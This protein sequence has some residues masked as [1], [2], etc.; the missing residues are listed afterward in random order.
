MKIF[1]TLFTVTI[2]AMSLFALS[3]CKQEHNSAVE[4][5]P[6]ASAPEQVQHAPVGARPG[7][8]EDWCGEHQVAE[9]QCTKCNPKLIAAF[10]ATGDWCAEHALPESQCL[11][12]NPGLKVQRPPK[13]QGAR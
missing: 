6:A 10:K 13:T 5:A 4:K 9:S 12:C 1:N 8:Y 7:S 2:L 11:L 3:G